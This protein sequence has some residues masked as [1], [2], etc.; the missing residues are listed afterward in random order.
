M[1]RLFVGLGEILWDLLPTGKRLGGAPANFA[2]I[3]AA[4]GERA[5]VASRIGRD[6]LGYEAL[7]AIEAHGLESAWMQ[8]D[9]QHPTGTA[10]V[11]L[12]AHGEARFEIAE[13]AAWDHLAWTRQW[14]T[15]AQETSAVCFGTLAQ[16]RARSRATIRSFL[17]AVRPEALKVLDLNLRSP[18]YSREVI[19]H[20]LALADV[21]KVNREELRIVAEMLDL[22]GADQEE[23]ARSLRQKFALRLVCLTLGAQGSLLVA[24]DEVVHHRGVRAKVVDS[25]G[26]GDAF[27]AVTTVLLLRGQTLDQIGRA[28]NRFAAWVTTQPGAM[29]P[30]TRDVLTQILQSS[31]P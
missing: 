21:V 13:D 10:R 19:V 25:V 24:Q 14:R 1:R 15:L 3:A 8:T 4:L 16:R 11:Q 22:A 31:E 9:E 30:V 20:S 2:Y 18:F 17:R 5:A 26:D 7:Q 27:T 6:R 29:P 12:D 23:L 28:A